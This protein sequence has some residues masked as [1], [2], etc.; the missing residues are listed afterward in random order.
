MQW[1]AC[2]RRQEGAKENLRDEEER[3]FS[4]MSFAAICTL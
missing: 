3:D 4:V 1:R 2:V